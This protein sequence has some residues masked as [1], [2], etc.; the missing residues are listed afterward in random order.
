M[1]LV[2][3]AVNN[4]TIRGQLMSQGKAYCAGNGLLFSSSIT[5]HWLIGRHFAQRAEL[6]VNALNQM[7]DGDLSKKL[8]L[9]GRDDFAW[10]AYEYD[11]ARQSLVKLVTDLS[12]HAGNV[13]AFTSQ[14]ADGLLFPK[15]R[16]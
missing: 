5:Q 9:T 7:A 16:P 10:L 1:T 8:K 13:A 4:V 6:L 3:H 2:G 11:S 15:L 14:L 12:T